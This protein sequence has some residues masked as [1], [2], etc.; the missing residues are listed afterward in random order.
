VDRSPGPFGQPKPDYCHDAGG[1]TFGTIARSLNPAQDADLILIT[2][3]NRHTGYLLTSDF[4]GPGP[5]HA[6]EA[7]AMTGALRALHDE[8]AVV[9]GVM[10]HRRV[11]GPA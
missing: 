8:R 10:R 6:A 7:V 1:Q 3:T 5:K 4:K 2:A 9:P 11:M